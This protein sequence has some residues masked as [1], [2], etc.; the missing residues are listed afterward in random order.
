MTTTT[1]SILPD[2]LVQRAG[3]LIAGG[4]LR[5]ARPLVAALGRLEPNSVRWYTL[6]GRLALGEGRLV[7]ARD[8][9]DSAI[10][11]TAES[12][13]E[14][15]ALHE[16]RADS[17]I[18]LGD[19]PG[20]AG[21]AA[22]AVICAPG[23]ASAKA[24]L[25]GVLLEMGRL[26]DALPCLAEAAA[27][28]PANPRFLQALAV[29]QERLGD[30]DAASSTLA[31]AIAAVPA[32]VA[33]RNAAILLA[34][35]RRDFAAAAA[36]GEQ[37]RRDGVVDA[38]TFGMFG[39]ALSSLAR[40]REAAEAYAEALKL[41]PEDPYVRH[42]VAAAGGQRCADR[43]APEYVR[44]VFDGCSDR[45]DHHLISLGYRV[46][47]LVRNVVAAA[48]G[49][50]R[51]RVLG[52]VLDLGCGTGLVGVVLDD[53]PVGPMTGVDLSPGMLAEAG[54]KGIYA[55]LIDSDIVTFLATDPRRWP[56]IVLA[57]VLVYFGRL[58]DILTGL[59]SRLEPGGTC[60]LTVEQLA[61]AE[62][63]PAAADRWALGAA[64]RYGHSGAYVES[65]ARD[66][67]FAID[68]LVAE[69]LRF[70]LNAPVP[71]WF[72]VLRRP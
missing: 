38:C 45:F 54:R 12:G 43:A 56:M 44:A 23:R 46:P 52:P 37:A 39:H 5:A 70:E 72:A 41:G 69:T 6:A 59:R 42:L 20:A 8:A 60:I 40:H 58:D 55:E 1:M 15:A 34:L 66:A 35:R 31:R 62:P 7:E 64:G 68:A 9:F 65:T 13:E 24:V 25:G 30:A 32:D 57:D 18:R 21:D 3:A 48:L 33:L 49:E 17:R 29:V 63:A 28:E 11:L 51:Q 16:L 26:D 47:G 53:L 4:R 14:G 61:S 50:R 36:L 19:L 10:G 2:E 71:G 22:E 27:S 67:G